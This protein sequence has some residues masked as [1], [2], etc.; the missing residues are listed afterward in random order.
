MFSWQPID[1][2]PETYKSNK[3]MFV[4]IGIG[5]QVGSVKNYTTDPYCV[6]CEGDGFVRWPHDFMPTHFFELPT[7]KIEDDAIVR[8][9]E[10][11]SVPEMCKQCLPLYVKNTA[12]RILKVY[13][14]QEGEYTRWSITVD[15]Y[16]L[17]W[18]IP[19]DWL[20][21]MT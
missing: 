19:I 18:H 3:R 15:A 4:V 13:D 9:K 1:R 6:W 10:N 7:T 11:V 2:L 12:L 14:S 20:E 21:I 8:I 17:H 16:G 5:I